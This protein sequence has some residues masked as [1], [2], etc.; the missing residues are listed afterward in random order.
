MIRLT[1]LYNLPPGSDEGAFLRWRLGDHQRANA[2]AE[3]VVRTDFA[4]VDAAWPAGASAPYRFMTV[5][6]WPDRASFERAFN[7]PDRQAA[8][9]AN[10]AELAD[11]LVLISEVL[12][13]T[14]NE[15]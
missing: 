12:V 11:P 7:D 4:R 15:G 1:V 8:M 10:L 13:Q 2:G 5:A 3:G 14:V 6:E 9:T